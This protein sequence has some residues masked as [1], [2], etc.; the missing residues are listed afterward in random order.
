MSSSG[1]ERSRAWVGGAESSPVGVCRFEPSFNDNVKQHSSIDV[2][3]RA[4]EDELSSQI[5]QLANA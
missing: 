5:D 2:Y 1:R 3:G 4:S